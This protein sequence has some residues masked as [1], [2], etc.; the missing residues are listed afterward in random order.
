MAFDYTVISNAISD[1]NSNYTGWKSE[2]LNAKNIDKLSDQTNVDLYVSGSAEN[3][4][5]YLYANHNTKKFIELD[6]SYGLLKFHNDDK[7]TNLSI[8]SACWKR[9]W[10]AADYT[11]NSEVN[12]KGDD[13]RGL[14]TLK[15][16]SGLSVQADYILR[17][18][19]N[20]SNPADCSSCMTNTAKDWNTLS[21]KNSP[22]D[23]TVKSLNDFDMIV[24]SNPPASIVADVT[25]WKTAISFTGSILLYNVYT[26]NTD[27]SASLS[28]YIDNNENSD[29][30]NQ[31]LADLLDKT[32]NTVDQLPTHT[33][34]NLSNTT[35][36]LI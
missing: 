10:H 16:K 18:S 7:G 29:T 13:Y 34:L 1:I 2:P 15:I 33:V 12:S 32:T 14:L 20:C 35:G 9:E 21:I 17:V 25:A 27:D 6:M 4:V 22:S 30:Y 3:I 31:S 19:R 36:Y 23:D 11:N 28:S 24:F 5:D 26:F 8:S